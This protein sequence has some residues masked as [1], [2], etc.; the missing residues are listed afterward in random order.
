LTTDREQTTP[1]SLKMVIKMK[2]SSLTASALAAALVAAASVLV[3]SELPALFVWAAFIGWASYDHSGATA[4]AAMRSSAA[5]VFGVVMAWLVALVVAAGVLPLNT[6]ASTAMAAGIASFLIVAASRSMMLSIVPATFYGFASTFAYLSL[7][8]E[9]LTLDA[10]T[11]FS[12]RNAIFSVPAS[13][14]IGTGLGIMHRWLVRILAVHKADS[15][16]LG[17]SGRVT[18]AMGADQ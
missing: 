4:Q 12:W 7:F 2:L 11:S 8:D 10:L 1:T 13:L 6:T 3:F 18:G 5:L 9:A 14:L 15:P 17:V 16:R